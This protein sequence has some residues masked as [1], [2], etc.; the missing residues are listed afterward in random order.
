[1]HLPYSAGEVPPAPPPP[2][3]GRV[4][5][6]ALKQQRVAGGGLQDAA[7][8][9]VAAGGTGRGRRDGEMAVFT[10]GVS[11]PQHLMDSFNVSKTHRKKMCLGFF[12]INMG[13][14]LNTLLNV[15]PWL[16]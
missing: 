12:D 8:H 7:R 13:F 16:A 4:L 6:V 14:H 9:L 2:S 11:E 3:L 1:M 5:P 15:G 10:T